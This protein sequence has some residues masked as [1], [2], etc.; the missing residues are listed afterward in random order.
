MGSDEDLAEASTLRAIER[1]IVAV[2]IAK[3]GCKSTELATELAPE[4][5]AGP[6]TKAVERLRD[7][8]A[9]IEIEYVL[10]SMPWRVKSFLLPGDTNLKVSG[11]AATEL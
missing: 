8:G 3:Q 7:S 11:P 4:I 2:V 5:T 10:P 9:L 1:T 6:L